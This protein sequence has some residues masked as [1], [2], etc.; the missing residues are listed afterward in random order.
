MKTILESII[1]AMPVVS[2]IMKYVEAKDL[3]PYLKKRVQTGKFTLIFTLFAYQNMLGYATINQDKV[4]GRK[5]GN[6]RKY[7]EKRGYT[8]ICR[9]K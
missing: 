7:K 8:K 3:N 2:S 6:L 4:S 9:E 5:Q 1:M